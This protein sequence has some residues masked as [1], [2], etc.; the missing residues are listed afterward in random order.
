MIGLAGA[1]EPQPLP[2]FAGD[3]RIKCTP[4]DDDILFPTHSLTKAAIT[5]AERLC[6]PCEL[7]AECLAYGLQHDGHF[8]V[9]GGYTAAGR[10]ALIRRRNEL[11]EAAV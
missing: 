10:R 9:Y 8:G 5:A 2:S 11:K 1:G 6:R 7:R 3:P 4:A